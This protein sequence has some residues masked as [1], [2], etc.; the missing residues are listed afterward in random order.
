MKTKKNTFNQINQSKHTK[1]L[2]QMQSNHIGQNGYNRYNAFGGGGEPLQDLTQEKIEELMQQGLMPEQIAQEYANQGQPVPPILMQMMSANGAMPPDMGDGG[3]GAM[4]PDMG[5]PMPGKASKYPAMMGIGQ[6]AEYANA[7]KLEK[8]AKA[9]EPKIG[10]HKPNVYGYVFSDL[11]SE[12]IL[13]DMKRTQGSFLVGVNLSNLF[14]EFRSMITDKDKDK[15]KDSDKDSGKDSGKDSN[16][17]KDKIKTDK[18]TDSEEIFRR[19]GEY[20]NVD[21]E[22]I[23]DRKMGFRGSDIP[24]MPEKALTE[25]STFTEV[26]NE[27]KKY[28]D[29]GY[30]GKITPMGLLIMTRMLYKY[31][32]NNAQWIRV[33]TILELIYKYFG[34]GNRINY[35]KN[36]DEILIMSL[37]DLEEFYNTDHIFMTTDELHKFKKDLDFYKYDPK[38]DIKKTIKDLMSKKPPII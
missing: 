20:V 23:L 14:N 4:P 13:Q 38:T 25:N 28:A 17:N 26:I 34:K 8:K 1:Q 15:N 12:E 18:L 7:V 35:F 31:R 3:Y 27:S 32:T 33:A 5:A 36:K 24:Q 21:F 11:I 22:K 9:Q 16:K 19:V 37:I 2:I 6:Y 10:A 30:G 29:S